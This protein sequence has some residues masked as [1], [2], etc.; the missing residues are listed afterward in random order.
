MALSLLNYFV[1]QIEVSQD[2]GFQDDDDSPCLLF[3]FLS[4]LAFVAFLLSHYKLS[5][6]YQEALVPFVSLKDAILVNFLRDSDAPPLTLT[7]QNVFIDLLGLS[8]TF[9]VGLHYY[10]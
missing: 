10:R 4:Y 5:K 6:T 1:W 2:N 7:I 8:R 9:L 3:K